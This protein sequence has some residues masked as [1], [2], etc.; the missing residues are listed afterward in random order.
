M[1]ITTYK[2]EEKEVSELTHQH[3][4]NILWVNRIISPDI[5]DNLHT[6]AGLMY[7][8][9]K[10]TIKKKFGGKVL[11]YRPKYDFIQEIEMLWELGILTKKKDGR[12]SPLLFLRGKVIGCIDDVSGFKA[13]KKSGK[14][15][16]NRPETDESEEYATFP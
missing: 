4:S 9:V 14:Y 7:L 11:L 10:T 12:I 15:N 3:L 16:F 8:E 1:K 5:E 6:P 2:G 13:F